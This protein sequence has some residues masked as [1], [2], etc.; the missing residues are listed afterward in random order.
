MNGRLYMSHCKKYRKFLVLDFYGEL[1]GYE[2]AA[3]E[4]HLHICASCRQEQEKLEKLAEIIRPV[5]GMPDENSLKVLRNM[6]R[7]RLKQQRPKPFTRVLPRPIVQFALIILFI[8]IGYIAGSRSHM[9]RSSA[10]STQDLMRDLLAAEQNVKFEK[11]E[12]SPY[13]MDIDRLKF[14]PENGKVTISYNTVNDIQLSSDTHDPVV[15]DL[16]IYAMEKGDNPNVRLQAV[17]AVSAIAETQKQL[18]EPYLTTLKKVLEQDDN[19]GIRLFALRVLDTMPLT[20]M[21]KSMLVHV[22]LYDP[23]TAMRIEALQQLTRDKSVDTEISSYLETAKEDSNDYIRTRS[24]TII[25]QLKK[26][27]TE[28][29]GPYELSRRYQP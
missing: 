1:E 14:D 26:Q 13:L 3:L 23:N 17:K 27:N 2:K 21:V 19:P 24:E 4:A 8:G 16:L 11:S 22:L 12:I 6:T 5:P 20:D 15:R 9:D 25:E 18:D 29:S 7:I 10:I 28:N